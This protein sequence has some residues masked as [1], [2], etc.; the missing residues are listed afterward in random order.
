MAVGNHTESSF[1]MRTEHTNPYGRGKGV[2]TSAISDF[3]GHL[4]ET[5]ADAGSAV[6]TGVEMAGHEL[7][8]PPGAVDCT[9]STK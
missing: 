2:H 5:R 1:K 7:A 9:G 6:A 3:T 4:A 8:T